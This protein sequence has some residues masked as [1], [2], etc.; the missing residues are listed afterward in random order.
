MPKTLRSLFALVIAVVPSTLLCQQSTPLV[1]D[2]P[3]FTESTVVV[4]RGVVQ[5]EAGATSTWP[6]NS[7]RQQGP[8]LLFRVGASNSVEFRLAL[9][10]LIRESL[11]GS[12]STGTDA[13]SAGL[14]LQMTRGGQLG[15]AVLA[16]ASIPT[17]NESFGKGDLTPDLRVAVDHS[18]GHLTLAAMSS[19]IFGDKTSF[20]QTIVGSFPILKSLG[21][22]VEY[23]GAFASGAD[24]EHVAHAGLAWQLNPD[25]QVDI[26]GG[27]SIRGDAVPFLGAGISARFR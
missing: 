1:T 14:K 11:D 4:G 27:R 12:S 6:K 15:V 18:F 19:A 13:A 23:A 2:R 24:T 26:H 21:A 5:L 9:P 8:E 22:F 20:E 7:N 10:N 17:G 25:L 3:D 16:G